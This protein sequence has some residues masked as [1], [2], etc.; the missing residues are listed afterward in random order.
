M[1]EEQTKRAPF[2]R[3]WGK[4]EDSAKKHFD[5]VYFRPVETSILLKIPTT[6]RS[7]TDEEIAEVALYMHTN[8]V[9]ALEKLEDDEL[10]VVLEPSPSSLIVSL[11]LT[12]LEP[13][14]VLLNVAG[15]VSGNFVPG[16]GMVM[17]SLAKG[18]VAM[19]LKVFNYGGE[20]LGAAGDRESDISSLMNVNDYTR[21]GHA[22]IRID[23]WAAQFAELLVTPPEH[24]VSDSIGFTLKPW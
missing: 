22:K 18:R 21:L 17:N 10:R 16:S 19:E 6:D 4:R 20:L 1:D 23:E 2:H 8:F 13:T 11:A 3:S 7:A 24:V 12:E 15:S 5:S 9:A 14:S